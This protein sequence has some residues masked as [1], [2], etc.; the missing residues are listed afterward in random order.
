MALFSLVW[1]EVTTDCTSE[2]AYTVDSIPSLSWYGY[3]QY[4]AV[5]LVPVSVAMGT[6]A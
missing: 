5:F 1:N 6:A 3:L 4:I 2:P